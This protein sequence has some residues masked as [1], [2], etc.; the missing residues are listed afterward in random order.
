MKFQN[1]KNYEGQKSTDRD[2]PGY[3]LGCAFPMVIWPA[4]RMGQ[5]RVNDHPYHAPQFKNTV[6]SEESTFISVA[7]YRFHENLPLITTD[8]KVKISLGIVHLEFIM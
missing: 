6:L 7:F 5:Y 1:L 3:K 4:F 8:T 2:W